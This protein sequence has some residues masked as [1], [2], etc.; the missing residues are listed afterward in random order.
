[1]DYSHS[2]PIDSS[3]WYS[4]MEVNLDNW[5][6]RNRNEMNDLLTQ[7]STNFFE[8]EDYG[9]F[10][11][12][13]S[14][15]ADYGSFYKRD[16]NEEDYGSFYKSDSEDSDS[17][18]FK[19]MDRELN[20]PQSFFEASFIN[21]EKPMKSENEYNDYRYKNSYSLSKESNKP[22]DKP[23]LIHNYNEEKVSNYKYSNAHEDEQA[24]KR[25]K[26][27]I[28]REARDIDLNKLIRESTIEPLIIQDDIH[29]RKDN[30]KL[31][32]E[33]DLENLP[34]SIL[35][36]LNIKSDQ[37]KQK[38]I[39]TNCE[40]S[41]QS[42]QNERSIIIDTSIKQTYEPSANLTYA[43]VEYENYLSDMV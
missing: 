19:N 31:S 40:F 33:I 20:I 24:N 22:F 37:Y 13:D 34:Q 29:Q 43:Q 35:D 36:L 42:E 28:M 8:N 27:K 39:S 21:A 14:N 23:S 3:D 16:S 18:D 41:I 15:E 11:K 10:Y 2:K 1:M 30:L 4:S 5:D 7:N 26:H 25:T 38:E 6:Q 9:S 12:R 32:L 17:D